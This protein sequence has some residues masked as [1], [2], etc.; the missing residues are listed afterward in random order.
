MTSQTMTGQVVSTSG[1]PYVIPAKVSWWRGKKAG[2]LLTKILVMAVLAVGAI[3]V[4]IPFYWM[5][6]V[7]LMNE[8]EIYAAPPIWVPEKLI[9]RNYYD[10]VT[11]IPFFRWA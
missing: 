11:T 10:A 3:A 7:S 4:L 8:V 9:W 2:R 6:A 5:V 1:R